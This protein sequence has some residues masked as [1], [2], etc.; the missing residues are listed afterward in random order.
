MFSN[1]QFFSTIF[2]HVSRKQF[3]GVAT[4]SLLLIILDQASKYYAIDFFQEPYFIF[5]HWFRF[6]Y[7]E[8]TGVAWSIPIPQL[9]L[10]ILIPLIIIIG[11]ALAFQYFDLKKYWVRLVCSFML[12]GAISNYIDRLFHGFVVDFIAVGSFP[13]FN[14]ADVYI[15]CSALLIAIFYVK[16][17]RKV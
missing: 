11:G 10:F 2:R 5:G 4:Y 13:I 7:A 14:L 6:I 1:S 16:M 12:A 17:E 8:N 9:L 3:L 15:T